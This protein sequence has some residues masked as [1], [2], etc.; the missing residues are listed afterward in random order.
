MQEEVNKDGEEDKKKNSPDQDKE[1]K[2]GLGVKS[3]TKSLRES[4]RN[5]VKPKVTMKGFLCLS[6]KISWLY[7]MSRTQA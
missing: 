3:A 4:F 2:T 6:L 7:S 5:M 1:K